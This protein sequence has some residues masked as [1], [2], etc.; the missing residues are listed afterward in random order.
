MNRTG[1]AFSDR[2]Q[3]KSREVVVVVKEKIESG[4]RYKNRRIVR[5]TRNPIDSARAPLGPIHS[6][7][8]N[9]DQRG[10]WMSLMLSD[11]LFFSLTE[12][13]SSSLAPEVVTRTVVE[14]TYFH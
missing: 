14:L 4:N 1:S 2:A 5:T 11:R 3:K 6:Q 10:R 7:L 9:R 12:T 13:E 8:S